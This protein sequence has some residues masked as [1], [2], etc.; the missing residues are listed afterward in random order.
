MAKSKKVVTLDPIE[1]LP[2]EADVEFYGVDISEETPL[3]AFGDAKEPVV[4]VKADTEEDQ[5]ARYEAY[6]EANKEQI[7][8]LVSSYANMFAG[9]NNGALADLATGADLSSI[10]RSPKL[11]DVLLFELGKR[12]L[13]KEAD[14]LAK[15][16]IEMSWYVAPWLGF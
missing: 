1:E 4:E 12:K 8:A 11:A 10:S 15:R 5:K 14:V 9:M 3:E 6:L 16:L 2:T 7:S 13:S